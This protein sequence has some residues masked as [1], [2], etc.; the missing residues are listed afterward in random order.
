MFPPKAAT[1]SSLKFK[2]IAIHLQGTIHQGNYTKEVQI[3][4][5]SAKIEEDHSIFSKLVY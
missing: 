5:K 3:S 2:W 1:V 4:A